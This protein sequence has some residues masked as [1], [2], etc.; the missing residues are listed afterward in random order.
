MIKLKDEAKWMLLSDTSVA[1]VQIRF[2]SG[3]VRTYRYNSDTLTF[4]PATGAP[5]SSNTA[6]IRFR[7]AFLEDGDYELIVTGRDMSNNAA[8]TMSYRVGFQVINKP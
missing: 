1:T 7:P 4:I 6:S 2:P 3:A 8:G 5:N